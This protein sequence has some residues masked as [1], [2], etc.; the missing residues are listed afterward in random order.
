MW[1]QIKAGVIKEDDVI[2][3]TER[4]IQTQPLRISQ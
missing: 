4:W 2:S 3:L 1:D